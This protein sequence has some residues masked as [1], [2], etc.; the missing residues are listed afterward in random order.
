MGECTDVWG[1]QAYGGC[2]GD[3]QMY[4]GVYRCMGH[5]DMGDVLRAYRGIVEYRCMEGYKMYG[6][7]QMY[8]RLYRQP[9]DI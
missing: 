6:G 5:T 9:L 4:G 1:I 2:I 8:D 7:V 3:I